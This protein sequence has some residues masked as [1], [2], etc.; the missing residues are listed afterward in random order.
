MNEDFGLISPQAQKQS[1]LSV[2]LFPSSLVQVMQLAI[3][4]G[5]FATF[6]VFVALAGGKASPSLIGIGSCSLGCW[7]I[8]TVF[9]LIT[10]LYVGLLSRSFLWKSMNRV[11]EGLHWTSRAVG[12]LAAGGFS[13][14]LVGSGMVQ[15]PV[16]LSLQVSAQVT[17]ATA[18]FLVTFS[19]FLGAIQFWL[20]GV[21]NLEYAAYLDLIAVLASV[22]GVQAVNWAV[23]RFKRT[24]LVVMLLV[25]V[26]AVSLVIVPV[27]G[28]ITLWESV[29]NGTFEGSF[30]GIC[31]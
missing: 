12:L 28:T 4:F 2:S 13:M 5:E 9:H 22:V 17:S 27:F 10:F 24:S 21:T 26:A 19:A 15:S 20:A 16:L 1:Q 23:R 31:R 8:V 18:L 14:L 29:K 6:L 3:I 7:A 30:K 25:G 11:S